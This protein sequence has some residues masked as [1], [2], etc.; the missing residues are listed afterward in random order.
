[1]AIQDFGEKIGGAKKD[2]W[3]ERGMILSDL[4][5]MNDAEK[6]KFIKK[7]AV[8][9]KP[10]YAA[11][12]AEGLPIRVAWF[13]K[14][15]RDSL[16]AKPAISSYD[17]TPEEIQ[18]K[19]ERFIEFVGAIRDAVM[20]C[21]TEA[22]VLALG[23]RDWL[24]D[25]G[26]V[27]GGNSYYVRPTDAAGGMISNKFLRAFIVSARDLSRYDREIAKKQFL[28]SDEQK[29]LSKYEFFKYVNAEWGTDYRGVTTFKLGGNYFYPKGEFAEKDSWQD[30]TYVLS[31]VRHDILGRNFESL[32]AAQQFVLD[33]E[34]GKESSP[35]Q[36]KKGK[37]RFT[38]PQLQHILRKGDDV[39]HG[40]AVSGQDYLDVFG[41]KGGEFGNWMSEMDRQVSLNLGYEALFDLAKALQVEL[42]DIALAHELS[43]A[44][45]A[46]GSGSALA[47]YEPLREVINL[48]KM[49]GAGSLA[50]EWG[51]A[52][53]D[54][55]GKRLG[56][57]EF[58]SE[59]VTHK[60]VPQSF[61]KLMDAMK[62]TVVD[63]ATAKAERLQDIEL[64]QNRLRSSI[65][66]QFPISR[67]TEEQI[68][69]KDALI[70]RYFDNAISCGKSYFGYVNS[71]SGNVD[72]DAL[73]EYRKEIVGRVIP[74]EERV[75]LAQY[76][77]S[78]CGRL[79]RLDKPQKVRSQFYENSVLFDKQ[80][81]KTDH[82]YWASN[83]EL[84][85]RA[86]ACYVHDKVDG[87]SDY[88]CGH[89]EACIIPVLNQRTNEYE[90]LAAIPQGEERER[91]NACFD[92]MIQEL[93][94]MGLF[95]HKEDFTN[96]VDR[97]KPPMQSVI[98]DGIKSVWDDENFEL[99]SP[100]GRPGDEHQMSFLDLLDNAFERSKTTGGNDGKAVEYVKD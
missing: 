45:G 18:E 70:Q 33:K 85:A 24:A 81:S 14:T 28:Y 95:H 91:I 76:Q 83:V 74:K 99:R 26:F 58:M 52:L 65:N 90:T 54:I 78:L 21:K 36:K 50:H 9:Q 44:F 89:S 19:Q 41:F 57:P 67:M 61:K 7:D 80:F 22:D 64:Y 3:K 2:L 34:S 37:T 5:E 49:R 82:G 46:R 29:T 79:E 47:H 43:I 92:E 8:W 86:F 55:I 51:H 62:F 71:G 40:R 94:E 59:N 56:L 16:G 6:L 75:L 93:K 66:R 23:K 69:R 68:A 63:D 38:P 32:E 15:V 98:P 27:E 84:F 88:L 1:M 42:K 53:D 25:N 97:F 12:V 60:N 73:S 72:I 35:Q 20:A 17:R 96:E 31:N 100:E 87:R 13:V 10:D 77:Y 4:S 30:G 11:L 39:R 48:T